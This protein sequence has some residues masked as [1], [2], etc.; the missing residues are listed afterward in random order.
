MPMD[1]TKLPGTLDNGD[2]VASDDT[3]LGYKILGVK[4]RLGPSGMDGGP[5]TSS[6]GLPVNSKGDYASSLTSGQKLVPVSPAM[7]QPLS[8]ISV[9]ATRMVAVK[10]FNGNT[11][12]VFVGG[13]GVTTASGWQLGP[14]ESVSLAVNDAQTVYVISASS[15][16]IVSWF[17]V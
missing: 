1:N 13:S 12:D 3:G 16:Q 10:A 6:N 14:G 5:V 4:I 7:A 2:M 8:G 11:D 9:G 17:V 15:G